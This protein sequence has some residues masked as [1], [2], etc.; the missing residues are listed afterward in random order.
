MKKVLII[1]VSLIFICLNISVTASALEGE[2][3]L[4]TTKETVS[5]AEVKQAN[6]LKLF[7][8][9]ND[10]E[11]GQVNNS[12]NVF[13][14]SNGGLE[15]P[16][17]IVKYNGKVIAPQDPTKSGYTFGGWYKDNTTFVNLFDFTNTLITKDTTIFAKWTI[18]KYTILFNSQGGSLVSDIGADYN[19]SITEPISPTKTGYIFGGWYK[20][21]N[22]LNEWNFTTSK[23]TSNTSLYTKWI[24]ASPPATPTNIKTIIISA[25]SIKLTWSATKG[26][27]GYEVYRAT[28]SSGV[29]SLLTKT[30]SLYYTNS[31]LVTGKT[32]YYK[33]RSYQNVGKTILYSKWTVVTS[34]MTSSI[35]YNSLVQPNPVYGKYAGLKVEIKDESSS[36]YLIRKTNGSELWVACNKVSVST[37][38]ATNTKY[39]TKDQ[40]QTYVN[41][42]SSFIS[43]TKYFTWVD[44]NRQRVNVFTGSAKH[45]TLVKS[46]SCATGNNITPSKRGVFT[47]QDKGASFVAGSGT[48]VKYWTRYSGNYMLHSI[49][50]TTGGAVCD[51]TIG[52]RVSHGCIRMPLDMAK[53]YYNT[54]PKG[55][56]IWVN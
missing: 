26:A 5:K 32:Y 40:L 18:N 52:K 36:R 39:L 54:I 17:Q 48:I 45:W 9:T 2:A 8:E 15:V 23:V 33:I 50:L 47:I 28:S 21:A 20:E 34:R 51:S 25:T 14:D 46:Y 3:P 19:T 49:I 22:C 24:V 4:S 30:T 43:N 12:D 53:W 44:L 31:G 6:T 55:S 7:V 38:P 42:T 11:A 27:S 16:V 35:V 41:V 10:T 1:T 29:Y 56:L 37:N 13:F